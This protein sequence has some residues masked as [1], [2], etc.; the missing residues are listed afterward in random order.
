MTEAGTPQP[1]RAK[2]TRRALLRVARSIILLY[3]AWCVTCFVLQGRLIYPRHVAGQALPDSLIPAPAQRQWLD[4]PGNA[5]VEA[6]LL[7]PHQQPPLALVVFIHGNAELIDHCADD[8]HLWTSRGCAV[9]LPEFRGYGRSTGSPSQHPIVDDILAHIAAAQAQLGDLPV[10]L[11]G[12]SIGSAFAVQAAARLPAPPLA[13]LL[14]SP[15]TS[16]L[17]FSRRMLLPDFI[18]L[19]PLRTDRLL[20]TFTCPILIFHT[21]DDEIVPYAHGQRLAQLNPSATLIT[22][23]GGHNARHAH[24][25]EYRAAFRD[26]YQTLFP[27]P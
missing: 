4:R 2:T 11:H 16:V 25:P 6:W 15:F 20:H 8:A 27:P 22:L 13:L 19:S 17:A 24:S 9:L 14:E 7:P 3:V 10:I 18:C 21:H 12:R 5:R 23:R 1:R 26:F